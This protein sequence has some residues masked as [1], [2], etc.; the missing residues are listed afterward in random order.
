MLHPP[1]HPQ[2]DPV[3]AIDN[4]TSAA[5]T[6]DWTVSITRGRIVYVSPNKSI[7]ID[8]SYAPSTGEILRAAVWR[9]GTWQPLVRTTT[10]GNADAIIIATIRDSQKDRR[11][12]L[13]EM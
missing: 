2:G 1:T 11:P 7:L 8:T 13:F 6:N 10:T 9:E 3:P 5:K 12:T 4:V